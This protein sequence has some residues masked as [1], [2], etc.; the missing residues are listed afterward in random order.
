MAYEDTKKMSKPERGRVGELLKKHS[1]EHPDRPNPKREKFLTMLK[2]QYGYTNEQSVAELERLLKQF[3]RTNKSLGIRRPHMN[4][5]PT[6][7]E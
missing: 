1:I 2:E 7:V 5:K 6:S 3:Y 4:L